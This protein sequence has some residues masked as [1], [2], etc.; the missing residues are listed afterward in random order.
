MARVP[1]FVSDFFNALLKA[2]EVESFDLSE[3]SVV[4]ECEV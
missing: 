3:K 1:Y 2:E 4:T